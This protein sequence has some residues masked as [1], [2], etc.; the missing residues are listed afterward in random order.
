MRLVTV[1]GNTLLLSSGATLSVSDLAARVSYFLSHNP[2]T[3]AI[4]RLGSSVRQSPE[5][6][7]ALV[8]Q[9][10]RRVFQ[11]GGKTGNRVRGILTKHQSWEEIATAIRAASQALSGP[12][13]NVRLGMLTLN[14]LKGLGSIS[15]ASKHLR[16]L[17]P[18][19]CVT[20]DSLLCEDLACPATLSTYV[21][22]CNE[23]EEVANLLTDKMLATPPCGLERWRAADVE[24]AIFATLRPATVAGLR[25]CGQP[26]PL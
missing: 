21:R 18:T 20:L 10:S 23:C 4:E 15:Y 9:F 14:T 24:I 25:G 13:P 1:Q 16:F 8:E 12:I 7:T 17:L 26:G 5:A 22:F 11:W 3:P 19:H 6:S 2:D